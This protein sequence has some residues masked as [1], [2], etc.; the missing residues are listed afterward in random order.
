MTKSTVTVSQMCI[1]IENLAKKQ[2]HLNANLCY[3]CTNNNRQMIKKP[4]KI[5][6]NGCNKMTIRQKFA[7][8]I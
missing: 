5:N 4:K 2:K 6:Q 8:S 7:I 3:Q 1:L